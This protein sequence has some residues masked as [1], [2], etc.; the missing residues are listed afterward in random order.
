MTHLRE[1]IQS[2]ECLPKFKKVNKKKQYTMLWSKFEEDIPIE[3]K[4]G[5]NLEI[6]VPEFARTNELVSLV[7]EYHKK[8][9]CIEGHCCGEHNDYESFHIP[10]SLCSQKPIT[11]NRPFFI[12]SKLGVQAL[13][14]KTESECHICPKCQMFKKAA[15]STECQTCRRGIPLIKTPLFLV[16]QDG[17]FPVEVMM[18]YHLVMKIIKTFPTEISAYIFYTLG[19]LMLM[20]M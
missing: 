20:L 5:D 1:Y 6:E 11:V 13:R 2:V 4:E 19:M 9:L 10:E 16:K 14:P 12:M 8:H 15:A 3:L 7:I 18:Q 17:V